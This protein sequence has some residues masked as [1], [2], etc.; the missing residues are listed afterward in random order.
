[1]KKLAACLVILFAISALTVTLASDVSAQTEDIKILS[2][3]YYTD[4]LGNVVIVGE[5]QNNGINIIDNVTVTGI[6]TTTDGLQASWGCIAS[7]HNFLPGQKSSFYMEFNPQLIGEQSWFGIGISN[8]ELSI[9]AAPP[10]DKYQYQDVIITSQTPEPKD[11]VYWVNLS[12]KNNGSQTA[13]NIMVYGTFYNSSGSVVAVGDSMTP[14]I[15]SLAPKATNTIRVPA[16]D[17]NQTLMPE[18]QKISSYRMLVQLQSPILTG[19]S[20]VINPSSTP[21]DGGNSV[22]GGGEDSTLIYPVIVAAVAIIIVVSA[23]LL[24]KRSKSKQ[25]IQTQK[26]Q[27]EHSKPK[28]TSSPNKK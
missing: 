19:N 26:K 16:F 20:P 24:I 2:Y 12:L 25:Q 11:G 23:I 21:I 5:I 10:T 1:M 9:Y 27:S 4:N 3:S 15:S 22:T 7:A 28:S 18:G 13:N 14:L 17:L 8:V 6:I